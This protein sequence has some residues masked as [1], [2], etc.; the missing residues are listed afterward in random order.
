MSTGHDC[1][2]VD[3]LNAFTVEYIQDNLAGRLIQVLYLYRFYLIMNT[4]IASDS[5]GS[6]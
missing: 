2:P 6:Y 4:I 5:D 1:N 3:V